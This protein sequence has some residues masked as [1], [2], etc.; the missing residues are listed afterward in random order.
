MV[1]QGWSSPRLL[2]KQRLT[3]SKVGSKGS[4]QA[5]QFPFCSLFYKMGGEE[6]GLGLE[7]KAWLLERLKQER[8]Q[9]RGQLDY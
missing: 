5:S 1:E 3:H 9:V 6:A 8:I 4:G 2:G 7:V